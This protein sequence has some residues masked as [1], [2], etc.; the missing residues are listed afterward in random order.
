MNQLLPVA[1]ASSTVSGARPR[2]MSVATPS[3]CDS[4][5]VGMVHNSISTPARTDRHSL[6]NSGRSIGA[7]TWLS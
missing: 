7:G 3:E 6:E 4:P 5:I 1:V 2:T